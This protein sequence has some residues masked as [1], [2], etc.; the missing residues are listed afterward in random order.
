MIEFSTGRIETLFKTFTNRKIAVIGDLMLDHYVW[1]SV[2][3]ISPEAPVPVVEAESESYRF[4]GAANVVHN[5]IALG[6]S[7]IPI[8]VIG[9][10]AGGEKL[11]TL[12][13][14]HHVPTEG[15]ITVPGRPTTMK[16]RIIANHQH[17]VRTDWEIRE[18]IGKKVTK[19][20]LAF[21]DSIHGDVDGIIF[22]DYNKGLLTRD[23]IR[24]FI[25]RAADRPTFV[26]PKYHHFFDYQGVTLFKPNRK[27]AEERLGLSLAS[28]SGR[29]RAGAELLQRLNCRAVMIT[30]GEEGLMLF[31]PGGDDIQ[32]PTR[33]V[34]V[35]DV[36]GAGDTVIAT[37]AV[38]MTAGATLREAATLANHAAGIVVGEVGIVPIEKER[39]YRAMDDDAG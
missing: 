7:A 10:D 27:E 22:E 16:T 19:Q 38:A 34:K 30:L 3:R 6:A 11:R 13:A 39:L 1:G 35:H 31:E 14:D 4:G 37:M 15:L 25:R 24:E 12:F 36:S 5:I 8:G 29:R 26:D 32:V 20:I 33:A 21:W 18:P 28:L 9:E 17:V 23:L 2:S